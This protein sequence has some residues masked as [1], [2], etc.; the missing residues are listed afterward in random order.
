M[1]PA[2]DKGDLRSSLVSVYA[3][4]N[5]L[6]NRGIWGFLLLSTTLLTFALNVLGVLYNSKVA[7]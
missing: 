2:L 1:R 5:V 6:V 4:F 3:L 7:T